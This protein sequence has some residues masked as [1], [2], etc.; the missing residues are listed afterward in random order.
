VISLMNPAA[1]L[2]SAG[3]LLYAMLTSLGLENVS[4][5]VAPGWI[6]AIVL[7]VWGGTRVAQTVRGDTGMLR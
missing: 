4:D 2:G 1:V 5:A 6:Y 7:L 3:F